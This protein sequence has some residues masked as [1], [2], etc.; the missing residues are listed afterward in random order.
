MTP[1]VNYLIG[2]TTYMGVLYFFYL[3]LLSN[4][5]HYKRNRAYLIISLSLSLILP[6]IHFKISSTASLAE[7]QR[8]ISGIVNLESV[9]IRP[10]GG[11]SESLLFPLILKIIYLSGFCVSTSL[12]SYYIIR[13]FQIIKKGKTAGS[14]KIY[15][16]FNNISGFSAFGY[17][18]LS[19]TLDS[20]EERKIEEHEQK[21]IEHNHFS[22]LVFIK[23]VSIIFW[24]NPFVYLYNR[25]LK[26]IHEYQADE[27]MIDEGEN[28]VSYTQ[29]LINQVFRTKL[30]TIQNAFANKTLIK[31]RIIMMTKQKTSNVAGL[32][33]LLI[34]PLA[35]LLF[36]LFSCSQEDKGQLPPDNNSVTDL[37]APADNSVTSEDPVAEKDIFTAVEEMPTF[38]GGDINTFRDWVQNSISYPKIAVENGI[39]GKVYINFIVEPDGTVTNVDIVKG[40]D[41]VLDNEALRAVK[42]SSLWTPGKQ[43]GEAV[44]VKFSITVNFALS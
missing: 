29:L 7:I 18:F 1:S 17:I 37:A 9:I 21:H 22:D 26:A 19:T 40:V 15:T 12:S 11:R 23:I 41:P 16:D 6:L 25:S 32:K 27:K 5:T 36:F 33:L 30:F 13:I 10:E 8:S 3:L 34:V 2:A 39:Q 20:D 43:R 31:K 42:E 35:L 28:P 4:D 24:F 14:N 38:N 44:R